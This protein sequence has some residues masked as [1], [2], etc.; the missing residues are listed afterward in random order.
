ML[1]GVGAQEE[2]EGRAYGAECVA[3]REGGWVGARSYLFITFLCFLP[4]T[5]TPSA[6]DSKY[7]PSK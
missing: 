4:A 3:D 5:K 7:I 6:N 2:D 1:R